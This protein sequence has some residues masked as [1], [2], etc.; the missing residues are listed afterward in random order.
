S[1]SGNRLLNHLTVR[2]RLLELSLLELVEPLAEVVL[3]ELGPPER[4]IAER[5]ALDLVE[6]ILG[7]LLRI[8][9]N[10]EDVLS[11]A[12]DLVLVGHGSLDDGVCVLLHHRLVVDE[13]THRLLSEDEVTGLLGPVL[14]K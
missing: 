5:L 9:E 14:A 12:D 7:P 3:H 2:L 10:H 1:L 4:V 11:L 8:V 13:R 6:E